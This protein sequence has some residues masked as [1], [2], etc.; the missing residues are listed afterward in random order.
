VDLSRS[1]IAR[2]PSESGLAGRNERA[3]GA[4]EAESRPPADVGSARS[5]LGSSTLVAAST[6]PDQ[7]PAVASDTTPSSP[8]LEQS[9]DRVAVTFLTKDPDVA[10]LR[11]LAMNCARNAVIDESSVHTDADGIT[12]GKFAVAGSTL[13]GTFRIQ[14]DDYLIELPM[15]PPREAGDGFFGAS[16]SVMASSRLGDAKGAGL[17][18]QFN[19]DTTRAKEVMPTVNEEKIV[20]WTIGQDAKGSARQPLTM[21]RVPGQI[22]LSIG[23][24]GTIEPVSMPGDW[25]VRAN[26]AWVEKLRGFGPK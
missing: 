6:D 24:S 1:Y 17:N 12:R 13:E 9:L 18:V 14:G 3:R 26:D 15:N 11:G 5:A 7:H 19:P 8:T 4:R 23:H 2:C 21:W 20:G 10:G 16:L 25:D 22:G